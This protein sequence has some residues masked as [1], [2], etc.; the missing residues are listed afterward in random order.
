MKLHFRRASLRGSVQSERQLERML[1]YLWDA[2]RKTALSTA[3][4]WRP[5]LD[6]YQ[7][8]H[9]VCVLAELAGMNEEEIEVTLFDD[10]VVIAGERVPSAPDGEELTYQ[11]AGV[12]Y[13]RFR[14]EVLLPASVVADRTQASYE[15][16]LLKVTMPKRVVRLQP[17]G[18][19]PGS[20][21]GA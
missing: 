3:A 12:R 21:A 15:Q 6:V 7:T 13:G 1:D 4:E 20:E 14:A 8:E 17:S 19:T 16:G 10:V 2:S 11:E 18:A 5:P 9:E